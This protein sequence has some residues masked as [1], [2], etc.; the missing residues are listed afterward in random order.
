MIFFSE[1][2]EADLDSMTGQ[3][4]ALFLKHARKI[5][6]MPPRRHM[7]Y[8]MPCHVEEVTKQA[9]LVYTTQGEDIYVI[10]CF[11]RHKDYEHW[12]ESYR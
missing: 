2:A 8:G 9:R 6:A 11:T 12:Y 1:K 5:Q 7:K 4:R 3:Q 10:R